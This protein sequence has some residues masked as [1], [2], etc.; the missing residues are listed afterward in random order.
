MLY[1]VKYQAGTYEGVHSVLAEEDEDETVI[2]KTKAWVRKRML[3]PMYAESYEIIE[4]LKDD[5]I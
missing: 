2:A 1:R 4:R 5:S 3:S